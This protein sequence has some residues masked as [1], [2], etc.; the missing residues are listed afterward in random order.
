MT[1]KA[2]VKVEV[3]TKGLKRLI[4]KGRKSK[5]QSVDVGHFDGHKHSDD[6]HPSINTIAEISWINQKGASLK[7]GVEIPPRPYMEHTLE[8]K[9][10][11][12]AMIKATEDIVL[13]KNKGSKAILDFGRVARD[14]MKAAIMNSP[15]WATSNAPL[16]AQ[17]KGFNHPLLENEIL[18]EDIEVRRSRG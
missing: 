2:K 7:G 14:M 8:G 9:A 12:Q 10:F 3:D 18:L 16:T 11:K 13:G 6:F 4:E 1:I 5:D 15:S 17:L